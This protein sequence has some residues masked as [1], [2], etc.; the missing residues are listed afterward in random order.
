VLLRLV[1][2]WLLLDAHHLQDAGEPPE[3]LRQF[4]LQA[5]L[6]AGQEADLDPVPDLGTFILATGDD[7]PVWPTHYLSILCV[8]L[9]TS[10]L[11]FVLSRARTV[12][13]WVGVMTV[14]ASAVL[15]FSHMQDWRVLF[16]LPLGM[17]WLAVGL[18]TLWRR[19]LHET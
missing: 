8:A 5:L 16:W 14:A 17:G 4:V 9:G 18:L 10:I 7:A 2:G 13:P 3:P 11:G 12:P 1:A 6:Q 19:G 15:P